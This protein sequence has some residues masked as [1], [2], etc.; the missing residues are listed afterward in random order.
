M[1][2]TPPIAAQERARELAG[3]YRARLDALAERLSDA[4]IG[5]ETIWDWSPYSDGV[6][7]SHLRRHRDALLRAADE[8]RRALAGA[9]R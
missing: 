1:T 5:G 6:P 3:A 2:G 9:D 4:R 7:E 8:A